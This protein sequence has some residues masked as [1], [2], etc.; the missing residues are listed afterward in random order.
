MPDV[1]SLA[2]GTPVLDRPTVVA[3]DGPDGSGKTTF[4]ESLATAYTAL[5]RAVHVVHMDDFLNPRSVRYARGRTSPE[6]FFHDTYDLAG[7]TTRVLDPLKPGAARS[8]S[9]RAFDHLADAPIHEEPVAIA[10]T[11]VVVIEGMFLHRDELW[12]HWDMSVFLN[13]PF[14]VTVPRMVQR[15]GAP[16]DPKHPLWF[17]Y[18]QGQRLYLSACKPT[19]RATYVIDNY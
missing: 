18:L 19:E 9:L 7:F 8:I 13:V 3:V 10:P 1:A 6:G 14:A 12:A 17:R 15:D 2:A 5:R 4:A 11:A 16:P